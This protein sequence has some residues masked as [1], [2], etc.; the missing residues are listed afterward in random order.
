[1]IFQ[2]RRNRGFLSSTKALCLLLLA[3]GWVYAL[4]AGEN[5]I[6]STLD[7]QRELFR[8]AVA[9]VRDGRPEVATQALPALSDY[10]LAPYLELELFKNRI[11]ELSRPEVEAYLARHKGSVVGSF[12]E[13]AWLS[14]LMNNQE[15]EAFLTFARGKAPYGMYCKYVTALRKTGRHADA[16]RETQALWLTGYSL[17]DHCDNVLANWMARLSPADTQDMHWRRARLAINAGQ[18]NLAKYLLQSVPESDRY[19]QLL[20]HPEKLYREGFQLEV[21][22]FTRE[23]VLHTLKRLAVADFQ[24]SNTL[25]HQLSPRFQFTAK[26][27][28]DL[29]DSLARQVIAGGDD[30]AR[31]WLNANDPEFEDPYLTEWRVRLALKAQDWKSAKRFIQALSPELRNKSDWQYWWARADIEA[32]QKMTP[33]A[34]AVLQQLAGS[35][36]YY[37]FLAADILNQDYQLGGKRTVRLELLDSIAQ[38]KNVQRAGELYWHD[39]VQNADREWREAIRNFSKEEQVAAAQLALNWGWSNAAV[40]T[41]IKAGEWDDLELRFPLAFHDAFVDNAKARNIDLNWAYAIARQES[42][43]AQHAQSR[44]GARG[45]MQLMP[46]TAQGIARTMGRSPPS[47][48]DLHTPQVNIEMGSFYLGQLLESFGG[49]HILA[50]A[51]Y[52]A[53]PERVKR[54]LANQKIALP[55]DIWIENLP[56]GE[57]REYIKNVLAFSVVYGLKLDICKTPSVQSGCNTRKKER[58]TVIEPSSIAGGVDRTGS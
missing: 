26:Q 2:G 18:S 23:L 8:E 54:V 30:S 6:Q 55:A 34:K 10:V 49:N 9:S 17:P 7:L 21:N 51:A 1:M 16:D 25:W 36:G 12:M 45:V 37:S 53:G 39:L 42:A 56:Y 35:R 40:M 48:K 47:L 46:A 41:A 24:S 5:Q 31:N 32:R 3:S 58:Y 13:R 27:R 57:T 52:N 22:D 38:N 28:F 33:Q 29:R 14:K 15:W 43:F 50:T 44:V 11:Y 4:P 19:Q 20:A